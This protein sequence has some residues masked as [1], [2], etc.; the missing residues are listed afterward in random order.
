MDVCNMEKLDFHLLCCNPVYD[1]VCLFILFTKHCQFLKQI[2]TTNT[3]QALSI[4]EIILKAVPKFLK[5]FMSFCDTLSSILPYEHEF[6]VPY[7]FNRQNHTFACVQRYNFSQTCWDFVVVLHYIL[8]LNF[9][10]IQG[11]KTYKEN[12]FTLKNM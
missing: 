7:N 4:L 6:H 9:H 12:L 3:E 10:I 8:G 2:K 5:I 11:G 1:S